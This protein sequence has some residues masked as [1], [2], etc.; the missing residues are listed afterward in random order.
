MATFKKVQAGDPLRFP[1]PMFNGLVDL[2]GKGPRTGAGD[3]IRSHNCSGI[4][5][6]HNTTAQDFT[7]GQILGTDDPLFTPTENLDSF[8]FDPSLKGETP[9]L[10]SHLGKFAV[11]IEPIPHDCVGKCVISGL[12][13]A[14]IYVNGVADQ[15]CD[16]IAKKTVSS[17]DCYLGTGGSGAKILWRDNAGSGHGTIVWAVVRLGESSGLLPL[18]LY[19]DAIP[20]GTSIQAWPVKA[21]LTADTSADKVTIKN[22]HP[23]NFRGYGSN[24]SGFDATTAARVW[25]AK[26]N[27]G[28]WQIVSGK[29]LAKRCK[30]T[31]KGAISGSSGTV[32]NVTA[33]DDGQCPTASASG[34]LSVSN[35]W[36]YYLA[37]DAQCE[38]TQSGST[39]DITNVVRVAETFDTENQVSGVTL[40]HKYREIRVNPTGDE[41][42]WETWHTGDD[43]SE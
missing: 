28:D 11:L 8:R 39:Y 31:A 26:D 42:A 36:N 27:N 25:C 14:R 5:D 22:T 3:V 16:V 32:D 18:I 34:E 20:G 15:Y 1:A 23:G 21:D 12:A 2:L 37:D 4:V 17:E 29:G 30:A 35:P 6:V 38:L 33:C 43:C 41:H 19:D 9:S 24:H 7:V 10:S 13:A 40:Q